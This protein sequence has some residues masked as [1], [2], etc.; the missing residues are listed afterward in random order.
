MPECVNGH[1]RRKW[2]VEH[3]F[4]STK[5]RGGPGAFNGCPGIICSYG[6]QVFQK[7]NREMSKGMAAQDGERWILKSARATCDGTRILFGLE[8]AAYQLVMCSHEWLCLLNSRMIVSE[9]LFLNDSRTSLYEKPRTCWIRLDSLL[10]TS[11]S[12]GELKVGHYLP[13]IF[14]LICHLLAFWQ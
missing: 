7:L 3:G 14:L 9:F 11:E 5:K 4:E 2:A 12:I 8:I 1:V 10:S 6:Q 13:I